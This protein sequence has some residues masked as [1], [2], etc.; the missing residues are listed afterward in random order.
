MSNARTQTRVFAFRIALCLAIAGILLGSLALC[1]CS[2]PS[3]PDSAELQQMYRNAV[4]DAE[5]AEPGEISTNLTAIVSYNDKLTWQAE[6]GRVLVVTWTSW[7]GYDGLVGNST[8]LQREVWVTAAPELQNFCR[9]CCSDNASLTLRLEQLQ[10]LPPNNSKTRMIEMWVS[11][12]DLFRPS[13]DPEI[14]DREAGIE[15]P[16]S[17]E[18][19]KVNQSHIDWYNTLKNASYDENGYPWTR[20]GYTYDWGNPQSEVGLSEFVVR[21]GATVGIKSVSTTAKYCE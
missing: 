11:P 21:Q 13:A 9:K 14:S 17:S 19:V 12:D 15:F 20:L 1:A 8:V 4:K 16:T 18:F 3:I 6:T 2:S 5:T 7:N 10:G